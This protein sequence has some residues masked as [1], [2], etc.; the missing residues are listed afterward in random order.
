MR[1]E[2]LVIAS[3]NAGKL[4]EIGDLLA[5][6]QVK[7]ISATELGISEP[8]ETGDSFIANARLKALHCAQASALPA[9]S[10]DSGLVV[11]ALGGA[12]GIYSARWAGPDKDFARAMLRLQSELETSGAKAPVAAHFV[13]ALCLAL[14]DGETQAFVGEVHGNLTFPARGDKGFG[15]DPIFVPAGY[16]VTF[17]QMDT[18]HK[19]SISHRADAFS[20]FLHYIQTV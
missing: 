4:R 15:Y 3:H 18:N 1:F 19:H 20:K 2:T 10:D 7:A 6:L 16:D 11:P 8:E 13:C 12:P 5:P 14:P 17:G 9:L